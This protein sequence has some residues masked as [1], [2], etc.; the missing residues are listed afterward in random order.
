MYGKC[1]FKQ[2]KFENN[3]FGFFWPDR[4]VQSMENMG[5]GISGS[6]HQGAHANE[7]KL[8]GI[9]RRRGA[10]EGRNATQKYEY[11]I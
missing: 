2:Q 9:D 11:N 4:D 8:G 6:P 10:Q 3:W 1:V 5:I 7:I